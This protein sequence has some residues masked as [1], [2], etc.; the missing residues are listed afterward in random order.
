MRRLPGASGGNSRF[1]P[2]KPTSGF[3]GPPGGSGGGNGGGS[4]FSG[5]GGFSKGGPGGMLGANKLRKAPKQM[6]SLLQELKKKTNIESERNV[7]RKQLESTT[8]QNQ[9]Q[10]LHAQLHQK[11]SE[12]SALELKGRGTSR[13]CLHYHCL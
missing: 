4:N 10:L 7:L 9:M 6:D 8:D 2:T 13:L 3:S 1:G 5:G 11:N 12:L